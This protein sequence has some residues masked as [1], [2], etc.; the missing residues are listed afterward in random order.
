MAPTRHQAFPA[1]AGRERSRVSVADLGWKSIQ[2]LLHRGRM[3][4]RHDQYTSVGL[5][6]DKVPDSAQNY[7][8]ALGPD[9]AV[10]RIVKEAPA[11]HDVSTRILG[12]HPGQC[13]P[14]PDVVPGK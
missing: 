3:F 1:R 12:S 8:V 9:N 2:E 4:D 5:H 7:H 11:D 13:L 10:A 14:G 6:H